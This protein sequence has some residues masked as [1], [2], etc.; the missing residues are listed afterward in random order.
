MKKYYNAVLYS[1]FAII[2]PLLF[3]IDFIEN[4]ID[5][6]APAIGLIVG[7]IFAIMSFKWN[8]EK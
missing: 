8:D 5:I 4:N 1:I 2:A 3:L 7:I 6:T